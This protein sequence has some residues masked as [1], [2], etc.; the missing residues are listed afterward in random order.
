MDLWP[1]RTLA[2][3]LNRR[4]HG[5]A[6]TVTRPEPDTAPIVTTGIWLPPREESQP[7]GTDFQRR[8]PRRVF[9]LP[10]ADAPT[11]PRGTIV[12]APE[13]TGGPITIWRVDGLEHAADPDYWRVLLTSVTHGPDD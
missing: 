6:A 2:G 11:M 7:Y 4:A 9:V 5:V 12:L 1:L 13:R 10:R 3:Q 8:D